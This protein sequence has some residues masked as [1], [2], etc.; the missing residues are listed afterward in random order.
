MGVPVKAHRYLAER[1]QQAI[2]DFVLRF[3]ILC[4]SS[5]PLLSNT[6]ELQTAQKEITQ[7]DS[8]PLN[9]KQG[10]KLLAL[11]R[12]GFLSSCLLQCLTDIRRTIRTIRFRI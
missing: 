7:N 12:S 3:L 4:A 11:L 6:D 1:A 5:D 9:T 2:A 10:V 8:P